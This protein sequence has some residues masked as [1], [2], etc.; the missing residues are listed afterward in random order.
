MFHL[1]RDVTN[2]CVSDFDM[3]KINVSPCD[4][5][6]IKSLKRGQMKIKDFFHMNFHLKWFKSGIHSLLKRTDKKGK[7]GI[8]Y[9][10]MIFTTV[11]QLKHHNWHH[12]LSYA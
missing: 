11:K 8:I 7:T 6:V 4:K 3:N 10:Y 12:K 1:I 2:Y 5:I 9:P